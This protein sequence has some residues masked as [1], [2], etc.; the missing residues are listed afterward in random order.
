M[1]YNDSPHLLTPSDA[2]AA[3][4]ASAK[5]TDFGMAQ[6]MQSG[7]SHASNVK[8]GT[9]LYVAPE[10][11]RDGRLHRSSDVY[12]FGVIMWE[13]MTGRPIHM[14]QLQCAP[15]LHRFSVVARLP[16]VPLSHRATVESLLA[17]HTLRH[18]LRTLVPVCMQAPFACCACV[19][20]HS[21]QGE[22]PDSAV[23]VR[24]PR[25]LGVPQSQISCAAAGPALPQL[26]VR[27]RAGFRPGPGL[28]AG[29]VAMQVG[30][31]LR[32]SCTATHRAHC[33]IACTCFALRFQVP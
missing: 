32:H 11:H 26:S 9:P 24:G 16:C 8:H 5:V 22:V 4:A 27:T 17:F 23:F 33:L 18:V 12:A 13:L 19:F 10:V 30:S 29:A 7:V 28:R 2:V 31:L 14:D 6:R 1:Q 25:W 3:R 15:H 20:Q 21:S